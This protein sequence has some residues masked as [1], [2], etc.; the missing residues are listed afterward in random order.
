M[1]VL[2]LVNLHNGIPL[3]KHSFLVETNLQRIHVVVQ[4]Q[5]G[6]DECDDQRKDMKNT[7]SSSKNFSSINEEV[8]TAAKKLDQVLELAD[9]GYL[10]DVLGNLILII[11][12][13][14]VSGSYL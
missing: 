9:I 4:P 10:E 11:Y 2:S 12:D 5:A 1:R 13:L 8:I 6:I 7:S 3:K 14:G